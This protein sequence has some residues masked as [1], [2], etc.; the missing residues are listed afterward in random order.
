MVMDLKFILTNS[1]ENLLKKQSLYIFRHEIKR[2][3]YLVLSKNLEH[4]KISFSNPF[5]KKIKKEV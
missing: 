4:E 3:K 1:L 5:H 2:E